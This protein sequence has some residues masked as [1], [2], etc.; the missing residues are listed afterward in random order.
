MIP[1]TLKLPKVPPTLLILFAVTLFDTVRLVK[2]P[3][4]VMLGC[5]AVL[6]VPPKVVPVIAPFTVKLVK[7]LRFVIVAVVVLIEF[8]VMLPL[9]VNA[10]KLPKLVILAKVPAASV[11]LN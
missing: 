4:C 2:V 8:D 10:V 6:I 9:T 11:P 3:T 1:G 7:P 5:K